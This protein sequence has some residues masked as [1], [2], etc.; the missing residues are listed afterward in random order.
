M[1]R[2]ADVNPLS[3]KATSEDSEDDFDD[4]CDDVYEQIPEPWYEDGDDYEN[5]EDVDGGEE[6]EEGEEGEDGEE[7]EEGEDGEEGEEGDDGRVTKKL[8]VSSDD[9]IAQNQLLQ[10]HVRTLTSE[11]EQLST[12]KNLLEKA[13]VN[14]RAK[15]I[16]LTNDI[17][18]FRARVNGLNGALTA[19]LE[20]PVKPISPHVA[21]KRKVVLKMV[22]R[23]PA[24]RPL[25]EVHVPYRFTDT[26]AFP[27]AVDLN[28]RTNLREN[29]IEQRRIVNFV[30]AANFDDGT[31]ANE[32]DL[33]ADG[34]VPYKMTLLYA[35]D[36]KTVRASDF[37]KALVESIT[38]PKQALIET[39][40]MTNGEL[41]YTVNRFNLSSTDTQPRH[42][43]FVVH[44][45]P[46]DRLLAKN[47]DLSVTSPP[48]VM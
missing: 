10:D 6:G 3:E 7:G 11:I 43:A 32:F 29:Q 23:T 13:N 37:T 25:H 1:Q 2:G 35:D 21:F 27:H 40:N 47:E 36:L 20:S 4:D 14:L 38:F 42:R 28:T 17:G 8:K 9:I 45:A 48:F 24:G 12:E 41:V 31:S 5:I 34:L 15:N 16:E 30:F 46:I 19:L 33:S 26:G 39:Q 22:I 44:V 18:G